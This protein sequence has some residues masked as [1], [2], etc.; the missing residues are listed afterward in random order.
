MLGC[1][2][3]LNLNRQFQRRVLGKACTFLIDRDDPICGGGPLL[4]DSRLLSNSLGPESQIPG[5]SQIAW[6]Q[7]Y[8]FRVPLRFLG[9][10]IT[11]SRLL[12][13][14][15]GPKLQISCKSERIPPNLRGFY[16]NPYKLA[17]IERVSLT[18]LS[19][20]GESSQI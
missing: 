20:F 18:I 6:G 11:D 2:L 12:S 3:Y 8:R 5:S 7:N 10:K 14:S 1:E 15:L 13:N 16:G 4:S 17:R 19:N 9:A